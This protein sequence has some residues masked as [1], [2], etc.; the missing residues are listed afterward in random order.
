MEKEEAPKKGFVRY[1]IA[2]RLRS[3]PTSNTSKEKILHI[4]ENEKGA[5]LFIDFWGSWCAP[6][7][8]ELP[9][10]PQVITAFK[11]LPLKFIF[12]SV[13]TTDRKMLEIRQKYGIEGT[14][15][16]LSRDEADIMNKI[17]DFS[18]YPH[19]FLVNAKG[20]VIDDGVAGLITGG[21]V[22]NTVVENIKKSIAD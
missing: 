21:K 5:A 15:I 11:G 10:Y 7:M 22:D 12:F 9:Y 6:C 8:A 14:F 20:M 3:L 16:N 19:H 2:E 4:L 13:E 18:S 1:D 17:F